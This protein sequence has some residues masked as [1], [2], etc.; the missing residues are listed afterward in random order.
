MVIFLLRWAN[1]YLS[2]L[3]S[4]RCHLLLCVIIMLNTLHLTFE[5]LV[6]IQEE[7]TLIIVSL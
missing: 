6:M 1:T 4:D 5:I 2:T 7:G 3:E